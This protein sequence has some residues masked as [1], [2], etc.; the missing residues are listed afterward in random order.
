MSPFPRPSPSCQG[1][2]IR[3]PETDKK[4]LRMG[5]RGHPHKNTRK[6]SPRT[7]DQFEVRITGEKTFQ[8]NL[9]G[10]ISKASSSHCTVFREGL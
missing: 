8:K 7:T 9:S 3:Q 4:G 10:P 6:R 1:S 5:V 2:N